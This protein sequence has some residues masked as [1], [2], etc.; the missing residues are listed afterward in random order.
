MR[1]ISSTKYPR[2]RKLFRVSPL[3]VFVMSFYFLALSRVE[4]PPKRSSAP[5]HS[6]RFQRLL[7]DMKRRMSFSPTSKTLSAFVASDDGRPLIFE[8]LPFDHPLYILYSSG[9]T[10]P[11]KGIVHSGGVCKRY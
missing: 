2:F 1:G 7:F 8:Q 6:G 3:R 5:F 4:R 9:T 11:P 10:G